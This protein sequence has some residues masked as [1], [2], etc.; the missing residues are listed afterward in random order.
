MRAYV[1]RG[2]RAQALRQYRLCEHVLR[3]EFDTAPEPLTTELF[4]RIR[5]SP[6][7]V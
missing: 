3:R 4:E 6:A 7:G 2:E 5:A 1:R